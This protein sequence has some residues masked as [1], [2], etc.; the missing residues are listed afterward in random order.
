[1]EDLRGLVRRRGATLFMVLLSVFEVLLSRYAGTDRVWVGVP[2]AGRDRLETEGLIGL[3]LNTLLIEGDLSGDPSFRDLLERTR[4]ALLEAYAHQELPYE[5]VARELGG[6]SSA[7][8]VRPQVLF[9]L[10]NHPLPDLEL[11][12]LRLR[13]LPLD[14][15]G[16]QAEL[17][18]EMEER[19]GT[20]HGVLVCPAGRFEP[21]AL[22]GLCD[23]LLHLLEGFLR[24]PSSPLSQVPLEWAAAAPGRFTS[25]LEAW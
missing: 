5:H 13:P 24:A 16:A 23:H 25:D 11:P 17:A 2:I 8:P 4:A 7:V 21:A 1:M 18:L 19:D 10:H 3:F 9:L 14:R 22:A 20:L 15:Q 12:G 6:G